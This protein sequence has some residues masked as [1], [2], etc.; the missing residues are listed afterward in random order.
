MI[1]LRFLHLRDKG[2]HNIPN[3]KKF[4]PILEKFSIFAAKIAYG[5]IF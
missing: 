2:T 3:K 1:S 5:S 4:L